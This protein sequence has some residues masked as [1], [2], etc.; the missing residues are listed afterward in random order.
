[1]S[2]KNPDILCQKVYDLAKY[3]YNRATYCKCSVYLVGIFGIF[4]NDKYSVIPVLAVIFILL[5]EYLQF[6]SDKYKGTAETLRRKLDFFHSFGWKI[7]PKD[8]SDILLTV[9]VKLAN[10]VES[11]PEEAYFMS[12]KSVGTVKSLENLEES[13]WWSKHLAKI[14]FNYCIGIIIFIVVAIIIALIISLNCTSDIQK[15]PKISKIITSTIMVLFSIGFVKTAIGYF[16]FHLKSE[17]IDSL[18]PD[19]IKSA[20]LEVSDCVK[21]WSEY[22]IAR[23][24]APLIPSIIWESNKA[25]LNELRKTH[26]HG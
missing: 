12:D 11:T 24:S 13:S 20:S 23:V 21:L 2:I 18:I 6:R 25:R 1:M 19:K 8:I 17:T 14:A 16:R 22:H 3:Y 10:E 5:S 7:S 15:I 9:P 26:S 4:I